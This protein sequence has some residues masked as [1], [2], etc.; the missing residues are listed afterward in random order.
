MNFL[1]EANIDDYAVLSCGKKQGGRAGL[2]YSYLDD[3]S[4]LGRRI[5]NEFAIGRISNEFAIGRIS[6]GL[7]GGAA[8]VLCLEI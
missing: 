1:C 7:K 8:R 5:S 6:S 3:V 4:R 2:N